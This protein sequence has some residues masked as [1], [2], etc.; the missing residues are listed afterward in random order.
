[1]TNLLDNQEQSKKRFQNPEVI[2]A[3]ASQRYQAGGN[4]VGVFEQRFGDKVKMVGQSE[5]QIKQP[6]KPELIPVQ[7]LVNEA[8]SVGDIAAQAGLSNVAMLDQ[9]V[10]NVYID[11]GIQ[12][13]DLSRTLD[14]YSQAA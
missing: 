8:K 6:A 4:L 9:A 10:G 7:T 14:D 1:M 3:R 13:I 12:P 2:N 5:T 11:A